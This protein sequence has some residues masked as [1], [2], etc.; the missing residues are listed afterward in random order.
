MN[1]ASGVDRIPVDLFQILKVDAM[2][3]AAL[4][5]PTNSE[6]SAVALGLEKVS[7]HSNP[8]EGQCQRMFKLLYKN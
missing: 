4:N 2:K 6:N 7:C 1:K 5:M 8:K 3:V